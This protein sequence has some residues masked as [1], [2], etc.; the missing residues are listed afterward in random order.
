MVEK[1]LDFQQYIGN[2]DLSA[3]IRYSLSKYKCSEMHGISHWNRVA[4]NGLR[5][6]K[7]DESVNKRVVILFAFL[8]DHMRQDDYSDEEHGPRA[9]E[10]LSEISDTLLADL[11]E[12]E[13][14]LLRTACEMH[15]SCEEGTGEPTVDACFD[16]D[17]LDF[18]RVGIAPDPDMITT[19]IGRHL[20]EILQ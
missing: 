6:A 4:R 8:H 9:A 17:R 12:D 3:V 14:E 2:I 11:S 1:A 5:I 16:A 10:A 13:F 18:G 15:T 7:Y 20:A 19:D